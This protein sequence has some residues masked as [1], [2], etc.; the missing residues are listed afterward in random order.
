[1]YEA[2]GLVLLE[3][4]ACGTPVVAADHS[5]LPE[6]VA[7]GTGVLSPPEDPGSLAEACRRALELTREPGITERCRAAAAPYD[8]D[9]AL[10]PH[11]E[12]VYEGA[13][14]GVRFA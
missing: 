4:L 10:A 12:A 5:A 7:P 1:V 3:S 13:V 11:M 6:L 2:F 8:W 9:T 14:E